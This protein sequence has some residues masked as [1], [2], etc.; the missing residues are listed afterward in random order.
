MAMG[1]GRGRLHQHQP[2]WG[3]D[4]GQGFEIG[5]VALDAFQVGGPTAR[6]LQCAGGAAFLGEHL[7]GRHVHLHEAVDVASRQVSG[8]GEAASVFF[9]GAGRTLPQVQAG[10]RGHR[11]H[12]GEE[13]ESGK[14]PQERPSASVLPESS[15]RTR[16]GLSVPKASECI[17]TR[18]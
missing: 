14:I 12:H 9:P 7:Q 16:Y 3:I 1:T 2:A 18:T 6:V 15:S 8:S 17:S 13:Q 5:V 11:Q 10:K 4:H